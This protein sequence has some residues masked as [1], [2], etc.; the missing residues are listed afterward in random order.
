MNLQELL[1][2]RVRL[3]EINEMLRDYDDLKEWKDWFESPWSTLS[4]PIG[5]VKE[6]FTPNITH[7]KIP[8]HIREIIMNALQA[9][10]DKLEKE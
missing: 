9:E 7:S 3:R 8:S 10:I 6:D 5:E 4:H 2:E 1:K